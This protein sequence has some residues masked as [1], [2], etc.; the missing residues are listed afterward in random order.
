MRLLRLALLAALAALAT[1]ALAAPA[2]A[3]TT[4]VD[5]VLQVPTQYGRVWAEIHRPVVPDG[6]KVPIILTY[7]P[8]NTLNEN[9]GNIADDGVAATFGPQGYARAVADV[10]GTRNSTGCWDYGGTKE[11]QS[12]VDLVN[13]LASQPWSNGKVAMMGTSYDGTTANMVAAR[14][15]GPK[16]AWGLASIVPI[17]AINHWY[18]YAYQDGV[19]YFGNSK[20]PSDEGID[21][22]L[23]FDF[24]LARTPPTKPDQD[25]VTDLPTGRY[26]PCDSVQHTQYGYDT[27]PDYDSFWQQR[28]YRKDA[29]QVRIP[30]LQVHGWQDYNVKQSEGLDMWLAEKNSPLKFL[31]MWQAPHAEPSSAD[32]KTLLAAFFACTLKGEGCD[33][34]KKQPRVHTFGRTGTTTNQP[35]LAATWPLPGTRNVTLQLGRENGVGVL[36]PKAGGD[37][38]SYTD[39]GTLTEERDIQEGVDSEDGWLFYATKPLGSPMRIAGSAILRLDMTDSADHGQ[40]SPT[41]V[42]VAPD[43]S[44]VPI[45]RGHLNLQYRNGLAHA[46]PVPTGQPLTARVR[47]AP[48]DQ[49]I[50]AGDRLGIIVASSN[51]VWAVPDEPAGYSI[52]VRHGTSKLVLP[53]AP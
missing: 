9:G 11:Q 43:G 41:L 10:I 25:S 24:G 33:A 18:G 48:Q 39:T 3:D 8:Y 1:G 2:L 40:L 30:V 22:P 46:D 16:G 35:T 42:D 15:N 17:A 5:E 32:Y 51:T 14:G 53:V 37:P 19:R 34:L 28:D 6:V 20:V 52:T 23:G 47:L 27:T 13:A 49:T 45:A 21:T 31:Y 36:A 50:P 44:V 38:L 7:S 29:A 4:Y 26:N 12:G